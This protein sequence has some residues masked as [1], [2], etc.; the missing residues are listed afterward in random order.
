VA[1]TRGVERARVTATEVDDAYY[2]DL[3]DLVRV[4]REAG[5]DLF[6]DGLL[7]W[8]DIFR[9]LAEAAGMRTNV[10]TRWFDNNA[11]Y[12]APEIGDTVPVV[13]SVD[14][15]VPDPIV[16][17]PRVATLPSPYL[18]S[19]MALA[20]RDRN[21]VM[22]ELA[23]TVLRPAAQQLAAA[24]CTLIHLQDPW[25]GFFGIEAADRTALEQALGA[26]SSAVD[27]HVVLHVSFGDAGP[28]LDW[29]RRLPVHAVGV[30]LV[31]TD[32]NSLGTDWE[33]GLVA[34]CIDGRSSVVESPEA[35]A[36]ALQHVA[37]STRTPVL[38]ASSSCELE[39]LP[40]T[41]A[42]RKVLVLGAA[43]QRLREPVTS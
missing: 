6:S 35:I 24:G 23:A 38:Y 25:L 31:E 17:E 29:L 7:R 43:A 28:Q 21:Q 2:G 3:A 34:G 19:R 12:R 41:V 42:D 9:P 39:L 4:Q 37:E 22:L 27:A 11:F 30:D 1:A 8:Q 14:R 18:F 36:D 16:P 40:R 26:I 33:I 10:L 15:I 13:D 20:K 32:I 5:L